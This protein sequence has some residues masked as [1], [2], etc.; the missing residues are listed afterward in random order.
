MKIY[1]SVMKLN[2]DDYSH[3]YIESNDN[4][5]H[6]LEYDK[7]P[8]DFNKDFTRVISIILLSIFI[9]GA[10]FSKSFGTLLIILPIGLLVMKVVEGI[11]ITNNHSKQVA[12]GDFKVAKVIINNKFDARDPSKD[13]KKSVGY[14]S[15]SK[16][17]FEP[18]YVLCF[19]KV[20][21]VTIDRLFDKVNVGDTL[22]LILVED[23]IMGAVAYKDGDY[24]V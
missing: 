2:L 11:R 22:L 23:Y 4:Y 8:V 5:I 3:L 17:D 18:V 12:D 14:I 9:L 24:V 15:E 7:F 13:R 20:E 19:N 16:S 6:M 1:K 10:V 21:Y